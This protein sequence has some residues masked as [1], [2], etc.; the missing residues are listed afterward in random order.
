DSTASRPAAVN[1]TPTKT[2]QPAAARSVSAKPAGDAARG[3]GEPM[4]SAAVSAAAQ[5]V[6]RSVV[7]L[8]GGVSA[9]VTEPAVV[10]FD[11]EAAAESAE[12]GLLEIIDRKSTRLNSSHVK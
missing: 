3:F 10:S 5:P 7:S 12:P 6:E 1:A 9:A 11:D 4:R 2:V 8:R